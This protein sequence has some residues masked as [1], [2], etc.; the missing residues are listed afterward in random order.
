[1]P[2]SPTHT[3]VFAGHPNLKLPV[4]VTPTS[5]PPQWNWSSKT[6][7]ESFTFRASYFSAGAVFFNL[8]LVGMILRKNLPRIQE[9]EEL[10]EKFR[11]DMNGSQ[12]T[13]QSLDAAYLGLA[14]KEALKEADVRLILFP[15]KRTAMLRLIHRA[16]HASWPQ[17]VLSTIC[18]LKDLEPFYNFDEKKI[19][20]TARHLGMQDNKVLV[21]A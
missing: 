14:I 1:M 2:F 12:N 19:D 21:A 11:R 8:D 16:E 13:A 9:S 20:W 6:G 17:A 7:G 10:W 5:E 15:R 18:S 4:G 3:N